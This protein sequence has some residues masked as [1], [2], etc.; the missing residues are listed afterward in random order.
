LILHAQL[1]N[2]E[3]LSEY[4]AWVS[5]RLENKLTITLPDEDSAILDEILIRRKD[6]IVLRE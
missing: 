1:A 2:G 4:P 5:R 6:N 3:I